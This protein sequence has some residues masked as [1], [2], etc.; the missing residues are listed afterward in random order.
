MYKI[1]TKTN[2]DWCVKAKRLLKDLGAQYEEC[3]LGQ[4]FEKDDLRALLGPHLPL[5]VPQVFLNEKRIGGYEELAEYL[6]NHGV[7]GLQT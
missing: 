1:Y 3:K 2:C 5:T 7:M 4:D 6:E